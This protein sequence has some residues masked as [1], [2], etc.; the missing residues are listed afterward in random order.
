M[1]III[2]GEKLEITKAMKEYATEKLNK[3]DK[4]FDSNDI[5]GKVLFKLNGHNQKV[6]ITIPIKGITLRVEEIG[7]DFYATIDTALDKLER[8]I[9]KNKTKIESR[10]KQKQK[11]YDSFVFDEV[12]EIESDEK[13]V[14][15][16]KVELIP[17]DEEE[18]ALQMEL[19]NHDFYLFK[20]V[21]TNKNALI[22]RRKDGNYG[23]IEEE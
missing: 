7:Q 2:R 21:H 15:R 10:K 23:V 6:E 14:K 17:M 18:A 20:N 5:E 4:Y 12:E 11:D 13:I 16:K 1:K 19:I 3:L 8:Q 22:Y 9:R